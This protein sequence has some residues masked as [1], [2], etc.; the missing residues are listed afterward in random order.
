MPDPI[1]RSCASFRIPPRPV[2]KLIGI[3][4]RIDLLIEE[5][6][7][8]V[9]VAAVIDDDRQRVRS[10]F[11]IRVKETDDGRGVP[12]SVGSVFLVKCKQIET[13]LLKKLL[14]SE[15]S[16][17]GLISKMICFRYLY[18]SIRSKP[19]IVES[20]N[21]IGRSILR[22]PKDTKMHDARNS[23]SI[24]GASGPKTPNSQSNQDSASSTADSSSPPPK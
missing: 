17:G 2:S 9:H 8:L 24:I 10:P 13:P 22:H 1:R 15:R 20:S 12:V 19:S 3:C 18:M 4:I 7:G 14:V 21:E 16:L 5:Y 23:P 11:R 6:D